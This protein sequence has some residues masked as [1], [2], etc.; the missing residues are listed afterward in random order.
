M[1]VYVLLKLHFELGMVALT[2]NLSI[3]E[4]EVGG[5]FTLGL[6]RQLSKNAY[7]CKQ[8]NLSSTA[9]HHI[10]AR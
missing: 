4:G 6:E 10:N 5:F 2:F 8:E 1:Y 7:F 3:M 9:K